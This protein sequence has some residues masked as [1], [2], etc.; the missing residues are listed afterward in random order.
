MSAKPSRSVS[1]A[2]LTRIVKPRAEEILEMVRDRLAASPFAAE[3]RGRVVLTGGACQLTGIT[4]LAARILGRPVRVG[5]PLGI[6]GLAGGRQGR[7]L[8]GRGGA[9]GLSAI[10]ASRTLRTAA[11]AATQGRD[12]RLHR[13]GRTMASRKLLTNGSSG[14][15][16]GRGPAGSNRRFDPPAHIRGSHEHQPED[17]RHPR[18]EAA[19]YRIRR[20]RRGRQRRQQHDQRRPPGRRF[21]RRQYR[22]PGA[23]HLARRTHHPDGRARRP[24]AS[25]PARSP[26]SAA[27]PPRR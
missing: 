3:P 26:M 11:H 2:M 18:A 14:F 12:G 27:P 1:R 7:G 21:R 10:R 16:P 19:D 9:L 8:R 17:S 23:D 6:S 24:K 5:R 4:D 20:R 25:A 15:R 22:R 13:S